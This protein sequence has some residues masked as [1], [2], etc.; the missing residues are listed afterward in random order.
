[1]RD[2][3]SLELFKRI[4]GCKNAYLTR[5]DARRREAL[6]RLLAIGLAKAKQLLARLNRRGISRAQFEKALAQVEATDGASKVNPI[7][8]MSRPKRMIFGLDNSKT[9]VS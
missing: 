9:E 2:I 8:W 3:L 1:V 5:D 7:Q 6:G 4:P